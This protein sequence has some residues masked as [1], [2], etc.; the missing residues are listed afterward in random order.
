MYYLLLINLV[1]FISIDLIIVWCSSI[2]W[3]ISLTGGWRIYSNASWFPS[4]IHCHIRSIFGARFWFSSWC[5]VIQSILG[6]ISIFSIIL[7]QNLI[8]HILYFP[9]SDRGGLRGFGLPPITPVAQQ[10][11]QGL[12]SGFF[13]HPLLTSLPELWFLQISLPFRLLLHQAC[14]WGD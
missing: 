6:F 4:L 2:D 13:A 11:E 1:C 8:N 14:G 12:D 3:I 5:G 9:Q 10:L 7:S